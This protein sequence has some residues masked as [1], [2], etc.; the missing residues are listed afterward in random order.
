VDDGELRR[1]IE[2]FD[3]LLF[4]ALV[5]LGLGVLALAFVLTRIAMRPL[6]ALEAEIA[7]LRAG[8]RERVGAG[9]PR[10]LGTL[11]DSLHALL[12]H[13]EKLVQRARS[14]AA[15]LAHAIKTPLSLIRTEAE[16]LGGEGGER[17][18]R[19]A[20]AIARH[21]DRSLVR[22]TALPAVAGRRTPVRA[23]AQAIAE[24]LSRLHRQRAIE[25]EVPASLAFRGAR[26]D[27]EEILG[28]LMENACKW[29][30][31]QVR[32]VARADAEV[33]EIAVEDDGSGLGPIARERVVERGT[34][35]DESAPG[36]GL[37]L[38]IA[39]EVIALHGGSLR[40]EDAPRGGLRAVVLLPAAH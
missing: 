20:D 30:R 36:S 22:G 38:S 25:V 40:L 2:R 3:M 39:L 37:G 4:A 18:A 27:L 19:H 14:H 24:T 9:A 28:N 16:E 31:S 11:V 7:G 29:A 5:T 10:E 13:D 21:T 12:E 33:L 1:E 23:V 6:R 15:D 32:V 8:D 34:R 17:I 26:E 35:L